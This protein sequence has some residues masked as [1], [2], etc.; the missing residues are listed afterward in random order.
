[1]PI[2]IRTDIAKTR[3][4]LKRWQRKQIPFAA[5]RALN[6]VAFDTRRFLIE[7]VWP[8]SFP[9]AKNARF[10][11]AMFRIQKATKQRLQSAIFDS[12][13]KDIIDYNIEGGNRTGRQGRIAIPTDNVQQ[14]STGRARKP[15]QLRSLKDS[16]TAPIQGGEGVF[17]R[18]RRRGAPVRLMYVLR[19]STQQPQLFPF[20]TAGRNYAATRWPK[21]FKENMERALRTARR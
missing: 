17:V 10:P 6:D 21:R 2:S 12:L 18:G 3:R 8:N 4:T 15:D 1:M 19:E 20:Y 11:R 7:K 9:N 14:T 13:D 16:F 5:S